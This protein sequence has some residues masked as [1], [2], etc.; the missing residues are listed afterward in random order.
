MIYI[1]PAARHASSLVSRAHNPLESE[2]IW[3]KWELDGEE[4]DDV[5]AELAMQHVLIFHKRALA[6]LVCPVHRADP[7]L[8]VRGST[9]ESLTVILQTCC[10]V[11]KDQAEERIRR[12][13]RKEK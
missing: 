10:P 1:R 5:A 8:V 4:I 3:V 9:L 2:M 11:L 13:S 7:W 6:G 12:A